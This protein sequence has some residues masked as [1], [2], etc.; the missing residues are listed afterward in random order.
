MYKPII[1]KNIISNNS[2]KPN[3]PIKNTKYTNNIKNIS[4]KFIHTSLKLELN[5]IKNK[6]ELLESTFDQLY[7]EYD[8]TENTEQYEDDLDE[9]I[10]LQSQK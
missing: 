1:I 8:E 10:N 7:Q 5:N 6:I 2:S 3:E 9:L 4:K